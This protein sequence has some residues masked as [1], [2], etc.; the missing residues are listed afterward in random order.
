ME[1]TY[2]IINLVIPDNLESRTGENGT[3]WE[4][5]AAG[6][7]A[8]SDRKREHQDKKP[9]KDNHGM[10][11]QANFHVEYLRSEGPTMTSYST[12]INL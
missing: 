2:A 3:Y 10:V 7:A 8:S 9:E 12:I 4:P 11:S 6:H 1:H 5:V